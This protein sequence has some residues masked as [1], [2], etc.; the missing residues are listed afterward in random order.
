MGH[1]DGAHTHGSGLGTAVLVLIGAAVAGTLAYGDISR[2]WI[3]FRKLGRE[4]TVMLCSEAD[5]FVVAS[6]M[7]EALQHRRHGL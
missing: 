2:A 7:L 4:S 6:P 5:A 3:R 1:P